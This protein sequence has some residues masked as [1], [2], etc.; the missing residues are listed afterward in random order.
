MTQSA[1]SKCNRVAHI[2]LGL[3]LITNGVLDYFEFY[4]V[5][6]KTLNIVEKWLF[7][8]CI[9]VFGSLMVV[10][11]INT[12]ISIKYFC[13][14]LSYLLRGIF[15]LYI[16]SL[17]RNMTNASPKHPWIES[18]HETSGKMFKLAGGC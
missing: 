10:G 17:L 3:L 8:L 15:D 7:P 2:L 16:A 5:Y 1:I 11:G 14:Y 4:L 12:T 13:W 18:V 9:I 6:P